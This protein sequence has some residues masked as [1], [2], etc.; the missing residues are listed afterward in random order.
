MIR[1]LEE[2]QSNEADHKNKKVM[3][4]GFQPQMEKKVESPV[5]IK[6]LPVDV[7]ARAP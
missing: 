6:T 3:V 5:T 4:F 1:R 2:A 7:E